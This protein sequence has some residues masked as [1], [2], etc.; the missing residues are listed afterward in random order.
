M[1]NE[2]EKMTKAQL[3]EHVAV[4]E[5]TIAE[6]GD[7]AAL[8]TANQTIAGLQGE[9]SEQAKLIEELNNA[10][11]AKGVSTAGSI[12]FEGKNYKMISPK[13]NHKQKQVTAET[14]KGDVALIAELIASNLLIEVK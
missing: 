8:N 5:K 4:L 11:E 12:E 1:A 10:L 7:A 3:I 2:L 14:L 9:V 13:F 6:S